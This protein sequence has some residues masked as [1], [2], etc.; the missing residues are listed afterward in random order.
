MIRWL[1][2][3]Y[4]VWLVNRFIKRIINRHVGQT[5][6]DD[7]FLKLRED[8]IEALK[9]ILKDKY[10]AQYKVEFEEPTSEEKS[11]GIVTF[12][13]TVPESWVN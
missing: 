6:S 8:S 5:L 1:R 13:L 12:K 10:V 3:K 7:Q 4:Q 2:K 9:S 11:Q